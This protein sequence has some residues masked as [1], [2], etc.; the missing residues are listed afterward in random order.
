[1]AR[2]NH[3]MNKIW[4]RFQLIQGSALNSPPCNAQ[5]IE[6]GN[7]TWQRQLSHKINSHPNNSQYIEINKERVQNKPQNEKHMQ[8]SLIT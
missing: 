5:C 1:M 7:K 4:C 8:V 2:I 6:V 3:K